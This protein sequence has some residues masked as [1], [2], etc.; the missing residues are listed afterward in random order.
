LST[1]IFLK[2]RQIPKKKPEKNRKEPITDRKSTC[3]ASEFSIHFD[4]LKHRRAEQLM[5]RHTRS[6][7]NQITKSPEKTQLRAYF[8]K[9]NPI[10][11]ESTP[12]HQ[13]IKTSLPDSVT[14]ARL[15]LTH[16]QAFHVLHGMPIFIV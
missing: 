14:A 13:P 7:P 1:K 15:T 12:S 4:R 16:T 10:Q 8:P 3:L 6:A 9:G 2:I 11:Y 5:V